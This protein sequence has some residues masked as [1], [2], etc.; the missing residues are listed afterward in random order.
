M[1]GKNIFINS[2]ISF[3]GVVL[4][5]FGSNTLAQSKSNDSQEL[6]NTSIFSPFKKFNSGTEVDLDK[7]K[8]IVTMFSLD[9]EDCMETAKKI[10]EIN[11][12]SKI[13]PVYFLFLGTEDQVDDFFSATQCR[14]PY[15][16]LESSIF[17]S[18]LDAPYP[19]RV[20]IM[21]NGKIISDFK[22]GNEFTKEKFKNALLY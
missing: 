1:I 19:P 20:C 9:C 2:F 8:N 15:I 5:C 11:I 17:F 13:P 18:L 4:I 6:K 12:T 22:A 7:G 10:D 14:F 21:M 3:A 16:I